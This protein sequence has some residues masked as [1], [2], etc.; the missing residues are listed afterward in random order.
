[1]THVEKLIPLLVKA[2]ERFI[3]LGHM[4]IWDSDHYADEL[5]IFCL[6]ASEKLK[7][8]TLSSSE[9]KK[10]YFI[11]APTCEWDDSVGDVE[12]GNTIFKLLEELYRDVALAE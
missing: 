3:A 6:N 10:L 5:G 4:D 12:L 11:F 7:N 9:K 2:S 8:G 1:M